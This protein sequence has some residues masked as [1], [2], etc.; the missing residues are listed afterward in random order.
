MG[1]KKANILV[2]DDDSFILLSIKTFLERHFTHIYT[3]SEPRKVPS[4]IRDNSIDVIILD[5]NFST[6]KTTGEEGIFWI[7][8]ILEIDSS[9]SIIPLTA[10]GGIEIAVEALQNGAVDFL[11][12]PWENEKM[13]AIVHAGLNYSR[14]KRKIDKLSEENQA[15]RKLNEWPKTEFIGRSPSIEQIKTTISKT[16]VTDANILILG[17]NG[18]GKELI[19][20]MIH[21][22]SERCNEQF[23]K[24]DLGAL[25]ESLFESEL[26][27]H[28]KGAFTDAKNSRAGRFETANNGTIF[29]DEIGNLTPAQQAKLLSV[30][31]NRE[32][33][34]VGSNK[35]IPLDIRIVSA[36]NSKLEDLIASGEY[37]SDLFYRLNTVE[38]KLPALRERT[39]DIHALSMFFIDKYNKKYRKQIKG[40]VPAMLN[41]LVKYHWPGNV[42]ELEHSIERAIILCDKEQ[43]GTNEFELSKANNSS[44]ELETYNLEQLEKWAVEKCL[45]KHGGNITRAAEELGLTRGAMYRRLEKY[46]IQ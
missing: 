44:M 41:K 39:E 23:V 3:E 30:I 6:G 32:I 36:T 42:R 34:R 31:Q 7:K 35:A 46:E 20:R 26:F 10:Y 8:K 4:F 12:K 28:V 33:F 15:L 14:S 27:G 11:V 16:A 17:E 5:M 29:L 25:S 37:R 43:L 9:I 2:I 40:I 18:T 19:A 1:L 22:Q 13:L 38:I 24:V 21:E 45:Q